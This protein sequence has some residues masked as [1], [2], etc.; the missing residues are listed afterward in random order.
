MNASCQQALSNARQSP[1]TANY[2]AIYNGF[3]VMGIAFTD[4]KPR[5]NVFTFNAW[6]ALGRQVKKGEHGVTV[7]TWIPMTKRDDQGVSQPIG[8]KP[9]STTVFHV[10]QTEPRAGYSEDLWK[11]ALKHGTTVEE[12]SYP[13]RDWAGTPNPTAKPKTAEEQGFTIGGYYST[14]FTPI[15]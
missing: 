1:S 6:I 14:E 12:K 3:N 15:E 5:E 7:T 8:R 9:K 4:I 13:S 10:S 2:S 11:Y